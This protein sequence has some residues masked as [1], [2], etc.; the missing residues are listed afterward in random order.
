MQLESGLKSAV[1]SDLVDIVAS[2]H[3]LVTT[4]DK[5]DG[6]VSSFENCLTAVESSLAE[7][8]HST[9]T[10]VAC[11]QDMDTS[12]TLFM[13]QPPPRFPEPFPSHSKSRHCH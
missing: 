1:T 13:A 7:V 12:L 3:T 4:V 2:T 11:L 8:A 6:Q 5:L 9:T 10:M